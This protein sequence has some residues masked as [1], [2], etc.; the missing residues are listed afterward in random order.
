MA[1]VSYAGQLLASF[2]A[3]AAPIVEPVATPANGVPPVEEPFVQG[4]LTYQSSV[5]T[6]GRT[7]REPGGYTSPPLFGDPMPPPAR[8]AAPG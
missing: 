2:A 5:G 6:T 3:K 8:P 7:I 4:G 1:E